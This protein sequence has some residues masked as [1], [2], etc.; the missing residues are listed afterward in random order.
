HVVLAVVGTDRLPDSGYFWA[1]QTQENLIRDSG[2][3]YT[4]VHA[5]QFFEFLRRITDD[6]TR[7]ETVRLAPV[8]FQP[9]SADDVASE[10]AR[11]AVGPPADGMVEVAGPDRFRL[12]E[13]VRE[14]LKTTG[15]RRRVVTDLSATYF[16]AALEPGSL[17]P[18]CGAHLA[19]SGSR[20][21]T[22]AKSRREPDSEGEA[23]RAGGEDAGIHGPQLRRHRRLEAHV[24]EHV[25]FGVDPRGHLRQGHHP[26]DQLEHRP[27]GDVLHL[28]AALARHP[29]AEADL[30]DL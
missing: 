5:T 27:L 15:D 2:I 25:L 14:R 11:V 20:T 6:A 1:K 4:I 23:H 21:G 29:A 12:D 26:V 17:V 8:L 30:G 10:I 24:G 19:P 18:G 16:G 7:G 28:L 9:I 13:L 22:P 3:P